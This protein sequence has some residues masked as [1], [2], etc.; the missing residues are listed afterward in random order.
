MSRCLPNLP[1]SSFALRAGVVLV[2]LV[3]SACSDASYRLGGSSRE[4]VNHD[5]SPRIGLCVR[6]ADLEFIDQ[7]EDGDG[8]INFTNGRAGV[9]F[10]FSDETGKQFPGRD[11]ESFPMSEL[12]PPRAGSRYAAHSFG[13][14]FKKWG[15][16]I[17]FDMRAQQPYNAS[18]Y[19]G[20]AFWARRAPGAT[21]A[22]RFDVPD[23]A[24]S[25]LGHQCE[26]DAGK[27]HDDF[28]SD[29][30]LGTDF[31]FFSFTWR[32]L[33]Q[34]GWSGDVQYQI[35]PTQIYGVRFQLEVNAEFDFWIDDIALLC[36]D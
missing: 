16:G 2:A 23:Q 18:S 26:A 35:D 14:G 6:G 34:R 24:T 11:L 8:S 5:G 9:W 15:S 21:S 19:A 3:A 22:V 27:C 33:S 10:P 30:D 7:M 29:L 12:D 1:R 4:S 28:G 17:G 32:S 25:P 31:H 36:H 13:S 20:I